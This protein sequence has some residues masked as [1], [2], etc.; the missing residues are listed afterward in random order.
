VQPLQDAGCEVFSIPG[1][2][3]RP[4]LAALLQELGRRRWTNI[5]VEGGSEVLGSFFDARAID[6]VHVF[7]APK[8]VGGR[9]APA[10]IAGLGAERLV[11][12]LQLTDWQVRELQ[13]DVLIHGCK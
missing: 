3:G 10:P 5:L 12:A 4:D 8:L 13:G 7:I 6:E 1:P 2:N 9:Q 11:D